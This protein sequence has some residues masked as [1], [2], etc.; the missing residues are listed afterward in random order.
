MEVALA[1]VSFGSA[2]NSSAVVLTSTL[3]SFRAR[4]FSASTGTETSP[5]APAFTFALAPAGKFSPASW[6]SESL[7]A[8]TASGK[9]PVTT[10]SSPTDTRKKCSGDA[11]YCRSL[12]RT[13]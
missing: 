2:S 4:N 10:C 12:T 11:M 9:T 3:N 8:G 13:V 1:G 6:I 7:P 5:I